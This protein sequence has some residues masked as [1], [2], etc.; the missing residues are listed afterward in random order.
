MLRKQND[1]KGN[2]LYWYI[3]GYRTGNGRPFIRGIYNSEKEAEEREYSM[4]DAINTHIVS[5]PTHDFDEAARKIRALIA[6]ET[7]S[8]G[9]AMRRFKRTNDEGE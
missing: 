9:Q 6:D 2:Q 8:V 3:W 1:E 7:H 4:T 5:Y